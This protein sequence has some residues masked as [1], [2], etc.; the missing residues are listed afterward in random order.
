MADMYHYLKNFLIKYLHRA[1]G[2][3]QKINC[4]KLSMTIREMYVPQMSLD[5]YHKR[6]LIQGKQNL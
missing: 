2:V 5:T 3:N 4:P 6:G 1:I